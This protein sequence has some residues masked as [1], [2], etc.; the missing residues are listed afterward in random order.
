MFW[1]VRKVPGRLSVH[2]DR[3]DG[4]SS[5]ESEQL[6]DLD[7]GRST[8]GAIRGP[9]DLISALGSSIGPGVVGL[10]F[11]YS[12]SYTFAF[13]A[14]GIAYTDTCWIE[15][16]GSGTSGLHAYRDNA[17]CRTICCGAGTKRGLLR[18]AAIA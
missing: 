14:L 13:L 17:K 16:P 11:D 12:Q 9:R 10:W 1:H 5:V 15:W 6:F 3:V 4:R 7:F 2:R 18:K 8:S